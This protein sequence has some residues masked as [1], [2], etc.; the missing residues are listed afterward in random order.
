M[1]RPLATLGDALTAKGSA[2]R[3]EMRAN[4]VPRRPEPNGRAVNS[5][6]SGEPDRGYIEQPGTAPSSQ[7]PP[8]RRRTETPS[9]SAPVALIRPTVTPDG[10]PP[11]PTVTSN[12][13]FDALFEPKPPESA[14]PPAP[15]VAVAKPKKKGPRPYRYHSPAFKA[16]AVAL[17]AKRRAAD[18]TLR[19][20]DIA[21]ELG[22]NKSLLSGWLK[23]ARE[24]EA[25]EKKRAA[26]KK[27][28]Q[29]KR[30]EPVPE[31]VSKVGV[32]GRRYFS[33]EFREKAARDWHAERATDPRLPLSEFAAKR[34]VVPTVLRR[35]IDLHDKGEPQRA[36]GSY[37]R[38]PETPTGTLMSRPT[39][40][41]SKRG[42]GRSFEQVSLE[43]AGALEQVKALKAE[44]R[45]LL[46]AED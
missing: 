31:S 23:K 3:A 40:P 27:A 21:D 37:P 29:A 43:L 24:A 18:P 6:D 10:Q 25:K 20:E 5:R 9:L 1:T 39:A 2:W 45:A 38:D 14:P 33:I 28:A 41:P 34:G 26:K 19:Q 4:D 30:S 15:E 16:E 44:L 32:D 7:A 8:P 13:L 17:L 12:I 11:A 22:I 35:W 46:G 42:S 36:I